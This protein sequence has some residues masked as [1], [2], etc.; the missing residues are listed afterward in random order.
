MR[1]EWGYTVRE[2]WREEKQGEGG[3][4]EGVNVM[5]KERRERGKM[6]EGREEG[7]GKDGGRESEGGVRKE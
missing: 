3:G 2:R 7:V 1:A 6:R 5:M 4:R